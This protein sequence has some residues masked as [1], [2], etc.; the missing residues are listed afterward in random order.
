MY[1]RKE[2]SAEVGCGPPKATNALPMVIFGEGHSV[3]FHYHFVL[4]L[5]KAEALKYSLCLR[6]AK[7]PILS[8]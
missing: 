3:P 1:V 5:S 2:K 7:G 6:R 4:H 8:S